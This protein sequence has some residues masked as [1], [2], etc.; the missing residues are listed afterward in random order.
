MKNEII[1]KFIS[2]GLN[3]EKEL[4]NVEDKFALQN[5]SHIAEKIELLKKMEKIDSSEALQNVKK[6][7][8]KKKKI[9]WKTYLQKAAAILI[10]PIL[11]IA[12]YQHVQINSY[13]E[14]ITYTK[15]STP[16][17]LRSSTTLPDGTKVWL[18]GNSSIEYPNQFIGK[19]RLI[20]MSGEAYF[21]VAKNKF[22]PFQV[23]INDIIVEATGTQF[24]ISS[25]TNDKFQEILLT[26]GSVNILLNKNAE[27]K[28]LTA[29][30]VNELAKFDIEKR[31]IKVVT[32]E[33]EKYIAWKSG[34]I[35]FYND[36][37]VEVIK[38][39]ERWYNVKFNYSLNAMNDYAFTGSF[40]GEDL[41]QILKCIELTTPINFNIIQA[42]KN[43]NNEYQKTNINI[44]NTKQ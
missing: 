25:Y 21:E 10:I 14:N 28:F 20:S 5:Y 7:I 33:P 29:L 36:A 9:K 39:L 23:K 4:L 8:V 41:S 16:P 44:T 38:K 40:T 3:E 6:R 43:N 26:E 13:T 17:T 27:K 19:E 22:K 1:G 34:K 32:V 42:T 31:N 37:M 35:I 30:K 18:N 12:I 11:S 24:N 15:I 2:G